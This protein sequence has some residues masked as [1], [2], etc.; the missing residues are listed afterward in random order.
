MQHCFTKHATAADGRGHG[1]GSEGCFW[2]PIGR[3]PLEIDRDGALRDP[4]K[5]KQQ[6]KDTV[7]RKTFELDTS[8][9]DAEPRLKL[10]LVPGRERSPATYRF[11]A[12]SE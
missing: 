8:E 3:D 1:H 2:Q 5:A 12:V 7:L 10:R 9:W 6:I 4:R 11:L